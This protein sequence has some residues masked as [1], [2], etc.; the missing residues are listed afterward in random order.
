MFAGDPLPEGYREGLIPIRAERAID[1]DLLE[2]ASAAIENALREQGFRGAL[3]PYTREEK[4]GELIVTFT[5]ARGPLHR[6]ESV[7]AA[8][9]SESRPRTWRRCCKSRPAIHSWKRESG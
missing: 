8:G 1:Q 5:I 2:D 9:R 6:V 7:E 3:A 4:S